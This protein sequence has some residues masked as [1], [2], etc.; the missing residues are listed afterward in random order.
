MKPVHVAPD[1][2]VFVH[3]DD[4]VVMSGVKRLTKA[5]ALLGYV[6]AEYVDGD[7]ADPTRTD[8]VGKYVMGAMDKYI[9]FT[10]KAPRSQQPPPRTILS[11]PRLPPGHAICHAHQ[12]D[13]E[14]IAMRYHDGVVESPLPLSTSVE[15]RLA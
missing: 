11:S 2:T 15:E 9:A 10:S 7:D 6:L 12:P 4:T 8:C 14:G 5:S 3:D 13:P 1:G